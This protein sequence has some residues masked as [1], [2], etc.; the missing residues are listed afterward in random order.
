MDHRLP[1][2]QHQRSNE[3]TCQHCGGII[4]R[5]PSGVWMDGEGFTVCVKGGLWTDPLTGDVCRRDAVV[6]TPL[7][8]LATDERATPTLHVNEGEHA[9]P[10]LHDPQ[11]P[12]CG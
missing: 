11:P 4:E 1:P 9:T 6:H 3:A 2:G 10:T 8:F 5:L 7:P 12:A